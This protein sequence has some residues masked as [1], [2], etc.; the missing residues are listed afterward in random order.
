MVYLIIRKEI[1]DILERGMEDGRKNRID[2][3]VY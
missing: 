3:S 2:E 1:K